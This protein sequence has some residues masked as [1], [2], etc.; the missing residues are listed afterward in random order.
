M[1]STSS[2][3]DM[4][5]AASVL[6]P[7]SQPGTGFL[8]STAMTFL[9]HPAQR[10]G[11]LGVVPDYRLGYVLVADRAAVGLFHHRLEEV[12]ERAVAHVVQQ[13]SHPYDPGL[14]CVKAQPPG[15][16]PGQVAYAQGML[17]PGVVGRGVYRMRLAYLLDPVQ[18]AEGGR[19]YDADLRPGEVYEPVERIM[20]GL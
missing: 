5:S 19:V 10:P 12:G 8:S 3:P 17:E 18:P 13:T 2:G 1:R 7:V 11:Y 6:S 15:H 20:D 14:L 4:T 9:R 16:P